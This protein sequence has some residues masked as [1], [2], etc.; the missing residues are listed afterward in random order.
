[1]AT[2][3]KPTSKK[4]TPKKSVPKKVSQK[5]I[6]SKAADQKTA[7]QMEMMQAELA[8]AEVAP[9]AQILPSTE[10]SLALWYVKLRKA[11]GMLGVILPFAVSLG[12]LIIFNEPQQTSI[13]AYYYTHMRD[14]LVGT[15]FAIGFFLYSYEYGRPD[16]IAAK[17]A[18]VAALGVAL[19]PT[20]PGKDATFIGT[21]HLIFAASFFLTLSYFCLFLFVKTHPGGFPPMTVRK[22]Q[23]NLLYRICG[24]V[25]I[26]CILLMGIYHLAG[27]DETSLANLHPIFWLEAIAIVAFGI[28]WLTKGEAILADEE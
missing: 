27:G 15:L 12:A 9:V 28:S 17:I 7:L 18:F 11:I 19:F 4:V 10:K 25:M 21:L 3:K 1:M 5:G 22:K 23:R 2:K 14:V 24:G 16:G 20:D 13:S 26:A 8:P 6:R